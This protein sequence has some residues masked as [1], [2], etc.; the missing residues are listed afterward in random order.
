MRTLASG[1]ETDE[2]A[3]DTLSALAL[4]LSAAGAHPCSRTLTAQARL[5]RVEAIK[6]RARLGA[7]VMQYG[8]LHTEQP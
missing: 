1:I 3:A 4:R 8:A 5:H 6:L 7:L 2:A